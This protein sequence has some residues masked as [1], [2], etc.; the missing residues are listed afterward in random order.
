[1]TIKNNFNNN[2]HFTISSPTIN[3]PEIEVPYS[4]IQLTIPNKMLPLSF[5]EPMG[6]LL[7]SGTSFGKE[8]YTYA[9][10]V[11]AFG[12]HCYD[13]QETCK[14]ICQIQQNK[15]ATTSPILTQVF[16]KQEKRAYC[17]AL[18]QGII[19]IST[20]GNYLLIQ[21]PVL[22]ESIKKIGEIATHGAL[23]YRETGLEAPQPLTKGQFIHKY[24]TVALR[25]IDLVGKAFVVAA[26]FELIDGED[27]SVNTIIKVGAIAGYTLITYGICQTLAG[28]KE[29]D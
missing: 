10:D 7:K 16:D 20:T 22:K 9:K 26:C 28:F 6:T 5:W 14:K 11:A 12:K 3:L 18:A 27:S 19:V 23:I 8:I 29:D 17:K 25:S 2:N 1:M 15:A 21:N 13:L 24:A 4:S